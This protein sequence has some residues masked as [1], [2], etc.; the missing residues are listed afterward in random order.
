MNLAIERRFTLDRP[1]APIE[2]AITEYGGLGAND[3][4]LDLFIYSNDLHGKDI[5]LLARGREVVVYV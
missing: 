1:R 3:F 2:I 5:M 4:N